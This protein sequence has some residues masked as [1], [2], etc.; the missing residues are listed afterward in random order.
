MYVWNPTSHL[1]YASGYVPEHRLVW[2]KANRRRL[3]A[4]E[5][6]HH[7]D[8]NPSN[9]APK[10]LVALKKAD[11][12]ALHHASPLTRGRIAAA[13]RERYK[14]PAEREK[15]REYANRRWRKTN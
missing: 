13:G 11:H 15:S 14:D 12:Y 7:L 3:R 8:G 9:N 1:A 5:H 4:G 6:V 10:N 2:E